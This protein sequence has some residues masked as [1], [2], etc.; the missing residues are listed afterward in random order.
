VAAAGALLTAVVVLG[1]LL[2]TSGSSY[3]PA[4][5]SAATW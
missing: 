5:L 1:V 2:L 4:A 3:M